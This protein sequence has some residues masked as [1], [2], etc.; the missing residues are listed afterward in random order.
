MAYEVLDT[1]DAESTFLWLW[2]D[3]AEIKLLKGTYNDVKDLT[4]KVLGP[5]RNDNYII[6]YFHQIL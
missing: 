4:G 5:F 3:G 2:R 6:Q 1:W